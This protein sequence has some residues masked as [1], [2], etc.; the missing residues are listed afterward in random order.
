MTKSKEALRLAAQS[1]WL[2]RRISYAQ[3]QVEAHQRRIAGWQAEKEE[4]DRRIRE[5]D[6][7]TNTTEGSSGA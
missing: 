2:D 7:E 3:E 4:T 5:L 1:T 6:E